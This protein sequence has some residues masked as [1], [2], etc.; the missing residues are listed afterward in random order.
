[1]RLTKRQLS[2][3]IRE[4]VLQE[5]WEEFDGYGNPPAVFN[6]LCQAIA[7]TMNKQGG[8]WIQKKRNA[9]RSL[10][11]AVNTIVT[12]DQAVK[13]DYFPI[14]DNPGYDEALQEIID[15]L[16]MDEKAIKQ[17]IVDYILS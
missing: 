13:S 2:R 7:S 11:N 8:M 16:V 3:I 15:D 12:K 17:I 4:A 6:V 9:H 10:K 14:R 5:N 1:M